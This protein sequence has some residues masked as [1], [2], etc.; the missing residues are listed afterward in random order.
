MA[1]KKTLYI[2]LNKTDMYSEST[3]ITTCSRWK[4]CGGICYS[5]EYAENCVIGGRIVI[6]IIIQGILED[7]D[8]YEEAETDSIHVLS[9]YREARSNA[10]RDECQIHVPGI[11]QPSARTFLPMKFHK[12]E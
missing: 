9:C 12:G 2:K 11:A 7:K 3:V 6:N 8:V 5:K 4:R 1:N 10:V